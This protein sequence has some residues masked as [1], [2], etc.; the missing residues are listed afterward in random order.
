M[1]IQLTAYYD[2]ICPFCN[3]MALLLNSIKTIQGKD[4]SIQWKAFS[5]EQQNSSKGPDYKLWE[6]PEAPSKGLKALAASKAAENQGE[7]VFLALHDEL[8]KAGWKRKENIADDA[9]LLSVAESAGLEMDRFKKEMKNSAVWNAVGKDH[10][11]ARDKHNI[12]GVPTLV[13]QKGR[14]VYV[15]LTDLPP[16]DSERLSL[17]E[18]IRD[19]AEDR[20]Y[21]MEL[22]RPDIALL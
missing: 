5:I 21:L 14:P 22:K 12:F 1:S 4:F 2:Y 17:F 15:K 9:V 13:F 18:L 3:R 10:R 6:H 20:P 16:S 8:F 19:M 11:E 7:D